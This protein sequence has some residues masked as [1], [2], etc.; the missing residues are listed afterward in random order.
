MPS[1]KKNP[2][3]RIPSVEE[4][5]AGLAKEFAEQDS[6]AEDSPPK[7]SDSNAH[8]TSMRSSSS[9]AEQAGEMVSDSTAMGSDVSEI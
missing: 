7:K 5:N 4:T 2:K 3:S 1:N 9:V 6:K 8:D